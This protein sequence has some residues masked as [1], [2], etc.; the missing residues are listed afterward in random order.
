[1]ATQTLFTSNFQIQYDDSEYTGVG[2][3][4]AVQSR[5]LAFKNVCESDYSQL[6]GWFGIAV[7]AGLGPSNRVIV[8]LTK[9][10]RGAVNFGY[11]ENNPR[12]NVNPELGA[13]DDFDLG[14]FVA[15]L[16]EILMDY[17]GRNR[18]DP[19]NSGGEG[20]SRV[21]A[22]LLHPQYAPQGGAFVN[23]WL[24]SD[25]TT[26]PTAAV[27]DSEFRKDWVSQNFTGGPLK[28]G[29]NVGGD[30]DSY[31]YGCSMLFIYYLKTQ[32][33][34]SMAQIIQNGAGTLEATYQR[35]TNARLTAFPRSGRSSTDILHAASKSPPTTPSRLATWTN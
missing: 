16:I 7:G 15:E 13:S 12:M 11:S 35:L 19:S 33:G 6:C 18:W 9:N 21:A 24:A 2:E 25:P 4:A 28:A 14:L 22:E 31:S 32:L 30:D 8:T 26:D 10:V 23:A 5:A 34:Y 29:G 20:L 3:L 27:A 1:M 17:T